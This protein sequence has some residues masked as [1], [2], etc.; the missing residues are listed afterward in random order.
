MTST[1][2]TTFAR[3]LEWQGQTEARRNAKSSVCSHWNKKTVCHP[4]ST[5]GTAVRAGFGHCFHS[6][7]V[8]ASTVYCHSR[9]NPDQIIIRT[10]QPQPAGSCLF[11]H[12]YATVMLSEQFG[13]LEK[14]RRPAT[15][16]TLSVY[17]RIPAA[18]CLMSLQLN[19]LR[20][21]G[22]RPSVDNDKTSSFA[23]P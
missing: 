20:L 3:S 2:E 8:A 19:L 13:K 12:L 1:T 7:H 9:P 6:P 17:Y 23:Y 22:L 10:Q 4:A 16:C 5:T 15:T 11:T 14:L 21:F 18:G